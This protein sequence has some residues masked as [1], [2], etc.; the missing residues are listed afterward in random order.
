MR[1]RSPGPRSIQCCSLTA[2]AV[3]LALG[4]GSAAAAEGDEEATLEED[5]A[6]PFADEIQAEHGVRLIRGDGHIMLSDCEVAGDLFEVLTRNSR[7][8][9]CFAVTGASGYLELELP[10][11]YGVRTERELSTAV[12]IQSE[13]TFVEPLEVGWNGIGVGGSHPEDGEATLIELRV[14]P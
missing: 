3:S 2:L 9:H 13:E 6:Y 11:A 12:V 8:S 10:A 5:F 14:G 1:M 7:D 4:S